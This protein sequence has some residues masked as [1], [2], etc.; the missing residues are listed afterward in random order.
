MCVWIKMK[1]QSVNF[2][3]ILFV[4]FLLLITA[5]SPKQQSSDKLQV[6]TTT[7]IIYDLVKNI[8][9]DRIEV[10]SLMGPGV[11]PHLY[12]A[13]EGDLLKLYY[14][15]LL[16]YSGL[17]L[18]GK[19]VDVF[20]KMNLRGW[21]T[22]SLGEYLDKRDLI[23]SENFGGNYDPH[24]W[25]NIG[26]FK[27]FA[28]VVTDILS[29]ND[30]EN[31]AYFK[32]N[33]ILYQNQL[34]ELE[35]E[36][37]KLIESLPKEKRI[38]VTAH[39]AFSY[40]GKTYGFEVVGLQGISTATEAGVRDV[41]NMRDF[42]IQHQIKSIFIE[43]SVPRR[44]IEALQAAVRAKNKEVEIGASLYSDALGDLDGPEGSYIGMFKYN[45]E[46]II[47]SLR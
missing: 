4:F 32:K 45:V 33:N 19:M 26:F 18:E 16:F 5:C 28:D 9:G 40:F 3:K 30:P 7:T 41:R 37:N 2:E 27:Q 31:A 13:S 34:T 21:K 23:S 11:D 22:F 38:L 10:Q 39:D 17:H 24:V 1:T 29:E 36:V 44:T 46:N 6:V 8:G 25:F 35:D 15:D 42:I 47:E 20:E 43:S 12:K 14:S